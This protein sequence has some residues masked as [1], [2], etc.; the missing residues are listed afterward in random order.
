V[1]RQFTAD[2]PNQLWVADITYVATWS[3]FVFVV[4][5]VDVFARWIDG[6]LEKHRW[7]TILGHGALT[8]IA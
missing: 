8:N 5:V 3:G 1:Q 4:F 7:N 2:R 6:A